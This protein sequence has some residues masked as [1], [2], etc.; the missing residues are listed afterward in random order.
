MYINDVWWYLITWKF[1]FP[2]L[3]FLPCNKIII[4][5]KRIHNIFLLVV[6]IRILVNNLIIKCLKIKLLNLVATYL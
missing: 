5:K 6:M 1:L 3:K 4:K 2:K